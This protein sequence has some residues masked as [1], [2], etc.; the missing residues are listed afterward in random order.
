MTQATSPA[1][2]GPTP[3]ADLNT[4]LANL[5]SRIQ[6]LLEGNL[7][8]VYLQGSFAV[9]DFDELSDLDF[10]VATH[11]DIADEDLPP[12]QA[13][14]AALHRLPG[15]WPERLEGSYAPQAVLRR[16]TAEPRDPPGAAPRPADWADPGTSGRPPRFYPLLFLGNGSD[17][18]VRSEHDNTQVV[19]WVLREK[20]IPLVGPAPHTL[21][22]PVTPEA[23]RAEVAETLAYAAGLV[24]GDPTNL[25]HPLYQRFFVLLFTRILHS[26]ATGEVRSKKAAAAWAAETL[27]PR[28]R[29]LIHDAWTAR[30]DPAPP[31]AIALAETRAYLAFALERAGG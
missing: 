21:I 3:Y 16:L 2:R 15:R 29:P 17:H 9:G 8:G 19:R 7:V 25:E 14:H 26:M 13:M 31:T 4:L 18:L 10:M 23:L 11:N 30:S 22:D 20:G 24:E 6:T 28:W 5:V 27:P 12:L 1:S